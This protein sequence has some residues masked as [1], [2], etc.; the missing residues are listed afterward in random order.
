VL[1]TIQEFLDQPIVLWIW[2]VQSVIAAGI[3]LWDLRRR[4]SHLMSLMQVVWVLTV[5][6]S[7]VVGLL[8]YW[9]T[10]RRQIRR[11]SLWRKSFRSVSH[12]YSGCGMGEV[13]GIFI[14]V[15]L[16]QLDTLWV[17]V[18]TF[19]LAYVA[20]FALTMGPLMQDGV[21]F[22]RALKD[23]AYAETASIAIMEIVAIGIDLYLAGDAT[24]GEPLFWTSLLLSLTCGL[25]AAYPVNV[26]LIAWGV[27]EGM[28]DP[29]HM[30]H[31]HD[32]GDHE[33]GDEAS[34]SSQGNDH[35]SGH[36]THSH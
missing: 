31:D 35:R 21:G 33:H 14:A 22:W 16:L 17:V 24:M 1:E 4:N 9:T 6:Y 20:G 3:T 18:L 28:H 25:L 13:A 5:L 19:S 30:H 7:G 36:L 8:I 27:K 11:D 12:C 23:A 10:G 26:A 34:D 29:R 15:G 32:H 2:V